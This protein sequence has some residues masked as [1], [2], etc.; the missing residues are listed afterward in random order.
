MVSGV[1]RLIFA[2]SLVALGSLTWLAPACG[3]DNASPT[4]VG[5]N[6]AGNECAAFETKKVPGACEVTTQ[7]Y[8]IAGRN[9]IPE[10][11]PVTYCSNPP[12]SG[13]HYPV[14]ANFQEY[15]TPVPWPYLVHD[16]EHGAVLLLYKCDA[17]TDASAGCPEVVDQLRSIRNAAAV[18]PSCD[19]GVKRII[20]AP[21]PTI[22]TKIA[23]SAWGYTYQADCLDEPTLTAFVHDNYAKGPEDIC[24]AGRTTF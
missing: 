18:D 20:I 10:G 9:H 15:T 22:P 13:D 17:S 7:G 23:A 2:F 12:S 5:N 4:N 11:T 1:N 24:A 21:S 6:D 14:W 16:L 3:S 8:S 19:T